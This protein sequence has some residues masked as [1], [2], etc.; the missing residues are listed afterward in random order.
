M[1]VK[2]CSAQS[3]KNWSKEGWVRRDR[4]GWVGRDGWAGMGGQAGT[5]EQEG[6]SVQLS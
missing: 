2:I 4:Q 3:D 6:T 1:F 5:D